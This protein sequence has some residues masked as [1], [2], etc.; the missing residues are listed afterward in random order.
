MISRFVVI[1]ICR[2]VFE[3]FEKKT[4]IIADRESMNSIG[5]TISL[6]TRGTL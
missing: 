2:I 1:L 6:W 4:K 5:L 3:V